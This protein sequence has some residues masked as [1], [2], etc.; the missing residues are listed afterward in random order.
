[1]A[2]KRHL[3]ATGMLGNLW[4]VLQGHLE[5]YSSER[6]QAPPDNHRITWE[7]IEIPTGKPGEPSL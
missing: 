6:E 5:I 1:M 3:T 2:A 4:G 7:S